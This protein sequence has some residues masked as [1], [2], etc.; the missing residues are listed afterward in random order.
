M[1]S[2]PPLSPLIDLVALFS[3]PGVIDDVFLSDENEVIW[4][5]TAMAGMIPPLAHKQVRRTSPANLVTPAIMWPPINQLTLTTKM[6]SKGTRIWC[7]RLG[8]L[9]DYV[10][11]NGC[12]PG[13]PALWRNTYIG[14]WY[15]KQCDARRD[16]LL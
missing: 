4:L 2:L 5:C 14:A 7:E 15:R 11:Y 9:H 8:V 1:N 16:G 12:L 6:V 10:L 13:G 3:E